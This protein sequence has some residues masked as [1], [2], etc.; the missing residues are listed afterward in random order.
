MESSPE[1]LNP[2]VPL[3]PD[4]MDQVNEALFRGRLIDAIRIYRQATGS[5]LKEAKDFVQT[6]EA[7]LRAQMPERF[8]GPPSNVI[9]V[10][11]AGCV[12]MVVLGFLVALGGFLLLLLLK[13]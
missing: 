8:T 12:A 5:G 4:L 7:R 2:D 10:R 1:P 11:L 13:R 6:L 3:E 9:Q